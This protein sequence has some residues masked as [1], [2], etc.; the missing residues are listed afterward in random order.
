MLFDLRGRGRRRTVQ[1]I[2]LILALLLGGG[3]V[4]FGIGGDV[5]GGLF[6]AFRDNQGNATEQIE[7]R[8]DS[9]E[10]RDRRAA[11]GR[12]GVGIAGERRVPARGPEQGLR[13]RR[14]RR[15][16]RRVADAPR[17]AAARVAAPPALAGERPNADSRG[18]DAQRPDVAWGTSRGAVS[19]QEIVL[20]QPRTRASATTPS[21]PRWRTPRARPARAT[22]PPSKAEELAPKDQ[23]KE[24]EQ[25]LEQAKTQAAQSAARRRDRRRHPGA[26]APPG[27]TLCRYPARAAPL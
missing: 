6:D 20:D 18:D 9:A 22:S 16:H 3:L 1:V 15:V 5:Q 24:L 4:L 10:K 23:R 17:Q 19:A 25:S 13:R 8:V 11:A 7:K 2:Y 27:G 12:R 14:P 21:S 26:P